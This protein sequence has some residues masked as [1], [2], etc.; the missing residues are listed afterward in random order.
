LICCDLTNRESFTKDLPSLKPSLDKYA[1]PNSRSIIIGT[2]CDLIDK[3]VVKKEELEE[4]AKEWGMPYIEV[5]SKADIN[6]SE[7]VLTLI[8]T[9]PTPKRSPPPPMPN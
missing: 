5:S 8:Q 3:I 7:A 4:L 6:I 1:E 9:I 2:K